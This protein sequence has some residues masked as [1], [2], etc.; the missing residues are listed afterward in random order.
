[1]TNYSYSAGTKRDT[2]DL[3]IACSGLF[4]FGATF[5]FVCQ[6]TSALNLNKN[7]ISRGT[8]EESIGIIQTNLQ[9]INDPVLSDMNQSFDC[10]T[11]NNTNY[12]TDDTC[13][14]FRNL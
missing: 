14:A 10:Q 8:V 6:I 7:Q 3:R 13:T 2:H 9:M 11:T 1:M 5:K 12:T 4:P